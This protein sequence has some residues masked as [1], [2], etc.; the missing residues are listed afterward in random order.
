MIIN[1]Q[2]IDCVGWVDV[3][4]LKLGQGLFI[5]TNHNRIL[6]LY[7]RRMDVKIKVVNVFLVVHFY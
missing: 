3:V 7:Y 1:I 2:W 4:I 5:G 6:S